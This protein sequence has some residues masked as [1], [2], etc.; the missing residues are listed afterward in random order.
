MQ[1]C[2]KD[3]IDT[4][5]RS[6]Q[7]MYLLY[8]SVSKLGTF[9]LATALLLLPA[10][11]RIQLFLT[12]SSQEGYTKLELPEHH[13]VIYVLG[14]QAR[15]HCMEPFQF[16]SFIVW[17]NRFGFP[18]VELYGYVWLLLAGL[19]AHGCAEKFDLNKPHS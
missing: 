19:I 12:I 3:Y 10:I 11:A 5:D 8:C 18:F 15:D 9:V 14:I 13:M 1:K 7:D 17:F 6:K 2:K 4:Q 16:C